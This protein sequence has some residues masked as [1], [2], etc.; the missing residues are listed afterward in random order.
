LT[1]HSVT[2]ALLALR[3]WWGLEESIG[4]GA[5]VGSGYLQQGKLKPP[6]LIGFHTYGCRRAFSYLHDGALDNCRE[7]RLVVE[8][9]E[10]AVSQSLFGR[11]SRF[12]SNG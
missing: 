12:G 11:N 2:S 10:A 3:G 9:P 6:I 7:R 8:N 5:A 4:F 1:T